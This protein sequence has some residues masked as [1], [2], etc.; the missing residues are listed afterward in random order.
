M[1]QAIIIFLIILLNF[2]VSKYNIAKESDAD[3]KLIMT[4]VQ[5]MT[6]IAIPKIGKTIGTSAEMVFDMD[7][8][9]YLLSI[10]VALILGLIN[11]NMMLKSDVQNKMRE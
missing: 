4:I 10:A 5:I 1:I 6:L 2:L 11:K 3:K 7:W 8:R 9:F